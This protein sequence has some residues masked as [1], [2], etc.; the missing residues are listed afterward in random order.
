M[1]IY[2]NGKEV[3]QGLI[4]KGCYNEHDEYET[5]AFLQDDVVLSDF[6]KGKEL[7]VQGE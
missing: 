5:T 3:W 7:T 6:S 2:I 4:Q 1:E